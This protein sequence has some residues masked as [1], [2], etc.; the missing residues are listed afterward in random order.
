[1]NLGIFELIYRAEQNPTLGE[2]FKLFDCTEINQ[3]QYREL[4]AF[5]KFCLDK[6]WA[7][8]D[9]SGL[10][11]P[12][13]FDKTDITSDLLQSFIF[14]NPGY[15]LYLFHPY[16]FELSL[17]NSFLDLAELEHPG[18][19]ESLSA[20]WR[21]IYGEELPKI[22]L[23]QNQNIC[24]HCNYFVASPNFWKSYLPFVN[25][26]MNLVRLENQITSHLT[27]YT[28][29]KTND[30]RLPIAVFCFE[31]CLSL[32]I[33]RFISSKK[34]INYAYSENNWLPKELFPYEKQFV[35][36]LLK[37]CSFYKEA[38]SSIHEKKILATKTYYFFRRF[39]FSTVMN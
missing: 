9:L 25:S 15:E 1:M 36:E 39:F 11:S 22:Y 29:S 17:Q 32:F 33:K 18:I 8:Y 5:E 38:Q 35:Q 2:P 7:E 19:T 10:F 3:P 37:T 13:F 14:K 6:V 4:F 28:L 23:P 16:P 21:K 31:R 30:A 20:I 12:K 26:F 27:P 24:C 34:I